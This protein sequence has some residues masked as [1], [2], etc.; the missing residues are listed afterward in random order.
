MKRFIATIALVTMTA[1]ANAFDFN[2]NGE[3]ERKI[4]SACNSEPACIAEETEAAA[5]MFASLN[6]EKPD[7]DKFMGCMFAYMAANKDDPSKLFRFL[8]GCMS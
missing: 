4:A 2:D 1:T 3:T 7:R 8:S 5:N 6:G